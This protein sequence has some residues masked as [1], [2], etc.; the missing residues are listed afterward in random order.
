MTAGAPTIGGL[1][2]LATYLA[3][4]LKSAVSITGG[5]ITGVTLNNS[6]IGGTTAAAGT[7]TTATAASAAARVFS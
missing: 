2:R 1:K 7:F 4:Q 3:G 6:V 5:T